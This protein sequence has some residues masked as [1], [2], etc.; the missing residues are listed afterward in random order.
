VP[1]TVALVAFVLRWFA[2][3]TC[4]LYSQVC[5]QSSDFLSH[6]YDVVVFFMIIIGT[7]KAKQVKELVEKIQGAIRLLSSDGKAK[8]D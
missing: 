1:L 8:K 7:T 5:E 3:A 6:V 4:S 2:D